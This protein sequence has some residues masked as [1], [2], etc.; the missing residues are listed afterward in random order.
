MG[1]GVLDQKRYT[2]MLGFNSVIIVGRITLDKLGLNKNNQMFEFVRAWKAGQVAGVEN[3]D[4][5][6][7]QRVMLSVWAFQ[8]ERDVQLEPDEAV[9]QLISHALE[10]FMAPDDELRKSRV[11]LDPGGQQALERGCSWSRRRIFVEFSPAT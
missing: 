10:M 5:L 8:H 6:S 2:C 4:Y 1:L 11:A 9:K 7:C 3:P